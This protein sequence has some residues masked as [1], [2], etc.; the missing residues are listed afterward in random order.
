MFNCTYFIY[1][2][3]EQPLK[4]DRMSLNTKQ[5]ACMNDWLD[6]LDVSINRF[7]C[8][9]GSYGCRVCVYGY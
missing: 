5:R 1:A 4:S 3:L 9:S 6:P 2:T 7:G 8:F